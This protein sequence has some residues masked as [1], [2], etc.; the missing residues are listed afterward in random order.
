MRTLR[1]TFT[2]Q[3]K[4]RKRKPGPRHPNG[5]LKAEKD[6]DTKVIAFR[7]PHRQ[8]VPESLRHD[9]RAETHLGRL[10]LNG[11]VTEE[12]CEAA[13]KYRRTVNA[14]RSSI[15]APNSSPESI[16]GFAQPGKGRTAPVDEGQQIR[17]DY[18]DVFAALN[19]AGN[20][21]LR[22]VNHVAVHDRPIAEIWERDALIVGL[23]RLVAYYGL[24]S[25]RK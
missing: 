23:R 6:A 5:D 16:A 18:D 15:S 2:V 22:A 24:T 9:Q 25:Q 7:M 1:A 19:E 21:A 20:R 8:S 17:K 3:R 12:Q 14:F 13:R 10:L 11:F 4:G